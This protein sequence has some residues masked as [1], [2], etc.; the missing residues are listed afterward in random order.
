MIEESINTIKKY[1]RE[2]FICKYRLNDQNIGLVYWEIDQD[3][4]NSDLVGKTT[5][6]IIK[7][8]FK[9]PQI[10]VLSVPFYCFF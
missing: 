10:N 9:K 6:R 8:K 3:K 4:I 5:N 2:Q 1:G 7:M